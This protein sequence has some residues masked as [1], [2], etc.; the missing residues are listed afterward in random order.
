MLIDGEDM[1]P[2]AAPERGV[3]MVFQSFAL[4]PHMTVA[5]NIGF[6]L[7]ARGASFART[8]ERVDE[9]AAQLGL[10]D[11][12]DRRPAQLS[13][14]E[15]QR[16]ALARGLVRRPRLLLMDEPLSNLD[17]P[18]RAGLRAEIK[19]IHR[20]T[21]TTIVYV[22]HD[23]VEALSLGERLAVL[24]GGRLQQLGVPADVY[25]RPANLFVAGFLGNPPMNL[26][27]GQVEEGALRAG[28]VVVP[29]PRETGRSGGDL[30]AGFRAEAT[31]IAPAGGPGFA[32]T[33]ELAETIGHDRLLRLRAGEQSIA[34]RPPA[35]FSPAEGAGVSVS[36]PAEDV[37]L[38]DPASGEAL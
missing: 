7:E 18:L 35:G 10:D 5:E 21:K 8:E 24:A 31:R 13:G 29:L 3:S 9:I 1:T 14:G 36:V 15:R 17:A 37:T 11:L 22:T 32:A 25:A 26:V 30:I 28:V 27:R 20:E 4:F 16:T 12:L 6:G 2:V 34:V 19:R 38:F 23:Q 33:V